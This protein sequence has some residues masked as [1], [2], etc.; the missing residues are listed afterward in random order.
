MTPFYTHF[1]IP[2]AEIAKVLNHESVNLF[3]EL[4]VLNMAPRENGTGTFNAGLD[5]IRTFWKT[6]GVR[7]TFFIEDGSGL[8]RFNAISASQVKDVLCYMHKSKN[9]AVFKST[10]P[11]A[12]KGTLSGFKTSDFPGRTLQCKSG[13]MDRVR[14]Y[15]GYLTCNS[16]REVAFAVMVNNFPGTQAEVG[17]KLQKLLVEMKRAY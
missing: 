12:G 4:M 16:G 15:A 1:S 9:A 2:L 6:H 3:A 7:D 10:L 5:V 13:S 14:A 17:R 8:S 11:E